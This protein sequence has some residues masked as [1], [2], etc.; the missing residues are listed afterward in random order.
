MATEYLSIPKDFHP[1][2]ELIGLKYFRSEDDF[3]RCSL[4]VNDRLLNPHGVLHGGVLYSMVDTGMGFALYSSLAEKELCATIEI[5]INYFRTV[6]S[7]VLI[8]TCR[9]VHRGRRIVALESEITNDE[10]IVA[11]ALG[12][13]SVFAV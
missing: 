11:K 10:Q 13:Y 12:T 2:G 3:S 4:E 8:C 7:G 1:F 9:I 5:K 6:T